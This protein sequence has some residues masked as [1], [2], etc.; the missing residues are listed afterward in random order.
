MQDLLNN[1]KYII[2][3]VEPHK[4]DEYEFRID[5]DNDVWDWRETLT[6]IMYCM[7]FQPSNVKEILPNEE[8]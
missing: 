8:D 7:G 1:G 3:I 4:G 6:K 5:W 2:K